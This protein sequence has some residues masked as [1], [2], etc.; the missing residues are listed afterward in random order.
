[1]NYIDREDLIARFGE[2]EIVQLERNITQSGYADESVS[3]QAIS[4][5]CEFV[6]SFLAVRYAMPLPQ[7][8]EPIRRAVAVVARY[9]LYKDRPTEEVRL[10]YEDAVSWLGKVASGK[11]VLIFP[12]NAEPKADTQNGIGVFVV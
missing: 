6:D 1:M 5:A 4:D 11:A 8:T 9:Y 10:A 12:A 3:E 2:T 7:V